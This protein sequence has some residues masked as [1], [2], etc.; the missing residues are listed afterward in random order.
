M[1]QNVKPNPS[2]ATFTYRPGHSPAEKSNSE[3]F[4]KGGPVKNGGK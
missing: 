3:A 1:A 4:K 2:D